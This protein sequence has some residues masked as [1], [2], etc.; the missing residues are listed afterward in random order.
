[1]RAL[2]V[3]HRDEAGNDYKGKVFVGIC[4]YA[5]VFTGKSVI[6]PRSFLTMVIKSME[7]SFDLTLMYLS[8]VFELVFDL[9]FVEFWLL[10]CEYLIVDPCIVELLG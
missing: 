7:N 6:W 4:Y 9:F 2:I 5:K 8:R 3:E 1:M 10:S